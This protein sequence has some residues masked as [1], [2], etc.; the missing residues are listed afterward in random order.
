METASQIISVFQP[1]NC[2][3]GATKPGDIKLLHCDSSL[4][5]LQ[6][7]DSPGRYRVGKIL[8]TSDQLP[9]HQDVPWSFL[10][11]LHFH[12]Q[13]QE[14]WL[15]RIKERIEVF[16]QYFP[17]W[18]F[19]GTNTY[20]TTAKS[21]VLH[22]AKGSLLWMSKGSWLNERIPVCFVQEDSFFSGL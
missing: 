13:G 15:V 7:A 19:L 14:F 10:C 2:N 17:F 5:N 6:K 12:N 1:K 18:A 11:R 9:I 16:Y 3:R 20:F 4:K 21:S 22:P 8:T